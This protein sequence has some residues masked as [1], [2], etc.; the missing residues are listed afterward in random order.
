MIIFISPKENVKLWLP[1]PVYTPSPTSLPPVLC[2]HHMSTFMLL[3]G[4]TCEST[5][6]HVSLTESLHLYFPMAKS[7]S[8]SD[9]VQ[10]T[11]VN[12]NES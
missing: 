8:L 12:P 1:V 3:L 4:C 7:I 5:H 11:E 9:G 10:V 2:M 6:A